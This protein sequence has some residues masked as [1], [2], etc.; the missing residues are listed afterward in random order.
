MHQAG[1]LLGKPLLTSTGT[2]TGYPENKQ[3]HTFACSKLQAGYLGNDMLCPLG[4]E[5]TKKG[6]KVKHFYNSVLQNIKNLGRRGKKREET[7]TRP[8]PSKAIILG[9]ICVKEWSLRTRNEP[10]GAGQMRLALTHA[11]CDAVEQAQETH[12]THSGS[13]TG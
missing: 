11:Q 2:R 13:D 1:T 7:H 9:I 8:P 5:G 4:T 3:Q 6:R 12:T 10:C